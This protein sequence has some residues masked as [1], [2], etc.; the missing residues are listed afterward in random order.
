MAG[1]K[2]MWW[3]IWFSVVWG[4]KQA[5]VNEILSLDNDSERSVC[6]MV[7][8]PG[9]FVRDILLRVLRQSTD[10]SMSCFPDASSL[11]S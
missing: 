4:G 2:L 10:L 1:V 9:T 11:S 6:R 5:L 8:L 7:G 3:S